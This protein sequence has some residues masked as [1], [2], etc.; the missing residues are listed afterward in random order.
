MVEAEMLVTVG[1][2]LGLGEHTKLMS[3]SENLM[4]L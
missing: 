2:L 1:Q 4:E 3:K